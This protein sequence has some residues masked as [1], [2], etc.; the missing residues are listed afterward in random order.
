[1]DSIFNYQLIVALAVI[2]FIHSLFLWQKTKTLLYALMLQAKRYAK[3]LVLTSGK[4]QE[5]WV[6]EKAYNLMPGI[7]KL[8]ITK[9]ELR[10]LVK[11]LFCSLKD[12][13][14]DGKLNNSVVCDLNNENKDES[15]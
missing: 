6:I 11:K 9:K 13:T 4:E 7:F 5:D 10:K 2:L 1:M 15:Q 3:D 14:D 8:F 12:L